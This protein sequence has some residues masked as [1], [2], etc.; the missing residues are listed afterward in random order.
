LTIFYCGGGDSGEITSH[1]LF[2]ARYPEN[3]VVKLENTHPDYV[4]FEHRDKRTYET[5]LRNAV[6]ELAWIYINVLNPGFCYSPDP[7]DIEDEEDGYNY[8]EVT[9]DV[10]REEISHMAL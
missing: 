5:S 6:E 2:G 1:E 9:F 3:V 4:N 8:G 10:E 7:D